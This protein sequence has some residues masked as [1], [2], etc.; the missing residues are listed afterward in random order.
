MATY[1]LYTFISFNRT[2]QGTCNPG[3]EFPDGSRQ[4][5]LM[6]NDRDGIWSPDREF[7]DCGRKLHMYIINSMIGKYE[8]RCID[9][10]TKN[11]ERIVHKYEKLIGWRF[12]MSH[13][14]TLS[15]RIFPGAKILPV[16]LTSNKALF[17]VPTKIVT[18]DC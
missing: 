11:V 17:S 8:Q 16:Y 15:R 4:M 1:A 7:P 12:Y 3:Y 2:C 6:C 14:F 13:K 18:P 5:T 10:K 9:K